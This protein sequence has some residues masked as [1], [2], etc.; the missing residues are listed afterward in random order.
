MPVVFFNEL[1]CRASICCWYNEEILSSYSKH[2]LLIISV[3]F[4][5][6]Q[7]KWIEV[8][9]R[10]RLISNMN[11]LRGFMCANK[12]FPTLHNHPFPLG[13]WGFAAL[14][15]IISAA[16]SPSP[17]RAALFFCGPKTTSPHWTGLPSRFPCLSSPSLF[18]HPS[19]FCWS[20][21]ILPCSG[22]QNHCQTSSNHPVDVALVCTGMFVIWDTHGFVFSCFHTNAN[23][24]LL[25]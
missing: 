12:E 17:Y 3:E 11:C 4:I 5:Q 24:I 15:C 10:F 22:P 8:C 20:H 21:S 14:K 25:S 9:L 23:I 6:C 1:Q 13:K 2:L 7:G 19:P 18:S 16:W